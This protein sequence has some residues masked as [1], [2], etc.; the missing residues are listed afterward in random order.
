MPAKPGEKP[1]RDHFR[2]IGPAVL[3]TVLGFIA[4]YQ[5]VD[6]AP[7]KRITI[8]TGG[9]DGAYQLFGRKYQNILERNDIELKVRAT[10][11]SIENLQLL[12][13]ESGGVDVA[14]VQGGTGKFSRSER[15]LA[16]G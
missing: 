16:L 2:I 5:F 11:G 14:F 7:P 6:P 10:A 9:A 12:E 13:A 3:I 15:L 8:A 4:A 1:F